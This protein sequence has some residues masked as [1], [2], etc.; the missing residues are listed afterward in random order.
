MA[1]S[2]VWC[3]ITLSYV[4]I[5]CRLLLCDDTRP[6]LCYLPEVHIGGKEEWAGRMHCGEMKPRSLQLT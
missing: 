5:A 3:F 6:S 2:R 4:A 1:G